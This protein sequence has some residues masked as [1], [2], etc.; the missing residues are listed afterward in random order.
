MKKLNDR[1]YLD[2][3][4]YNLILCEKKTA[5]KGTMYK[6]MELGIEYTLEELAL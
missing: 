4:S 2:S 3:E 1:Y 5:K 6:G